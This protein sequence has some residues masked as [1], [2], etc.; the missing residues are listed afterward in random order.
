MIDARNLGFRYHG[1]RWVFRGLDV[2]VGPATITSLLGSNGAGKST[3]LRLLAGITDP[4]EGSVTR[5]G[6]VGF[7]PQATAGV[8]QYPVFDMVL[9]GRARRL[10]MFSQPGARDRRI[11]A[12][13]L[14]RVG[15]SHLASRP[16]TGL[17]GG[18]QQLILIARALATECDTL[19][20]DEPVSALDLRNQAKV[21]EL[22][23]DLRRE[24]MAVV[25][26]T[27]SPEH[28]LHLGGQ[29]LVL[30]PV[31]GLRAGPADQLLA[32]DVLSD[33]Y[34][35]DLFRVAVPDGERR[36]DIVVTRYDSV[37][38]AVTVP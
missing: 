6:E 3:L 20:L 14:D 30:D 16:F 31:E 23:V 17:S 9:M 37:R 32:D 22:L 24:G 10:G 8:F 34:G 25:L 21:L 33:L 28:A 35:I 38:D 12:D 2:T 5:D 26:S 1:G 4:S 29:A 18:Q 11:A 19:I 27:H 7:V 13:A 15:M 36:R